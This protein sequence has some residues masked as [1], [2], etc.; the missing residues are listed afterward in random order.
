MSEFN[1]FSDYLET[2]SILNE[3]S[4]GLNIEIDYG[5]YGKRPIVSP[6]MNA[7]GLHKW[8]GAINY[9]TVGKNI[10]YTILELE[11]YD[12]KEFGSKGVFAITSDRMFHQERTIVQIRGDKVYFINNDKYEQGEINFGGRGNKI[13]VFSVRNPDYNEKDVKALIG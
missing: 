13:K 1:S 11:D 4:G 12:K 5:D 7:S 10:W 2:G 9:S 3:S 8:I 6:K